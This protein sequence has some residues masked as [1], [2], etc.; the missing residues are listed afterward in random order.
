MSSVDTI[1]SLAIGFG[2]LGVAILGTWIGYLSLKAM[3]CTLH[4]GI[5]AR[6]TVFNTH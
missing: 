3:K 6:A 2:G 4:S 1:T 5:K